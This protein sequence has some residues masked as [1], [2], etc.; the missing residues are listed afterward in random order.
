MSTI[1]N[2]SR[3]IERLESTIR[4]Y[5]HLYYNKDPRITDQEFDALIEALRQVSPESPV[6]SEVGS[7]IDKS[8]GWPEVKHPYR[9]RSLAN[10]MTIDEYKK[11]IVRSRVGPGKEL[12]LE[13]KLDGCAIDLIYENGE[14]VQALTRGDG[15]VGADITP[16]VRKM[17]FFKAKLPESINACIY[18]EVIM[19]KADFEEL[20][21]RL[22]KKKDG[23]NAFAN[24][25]NAATGISH[26][27]DGLYSDSLSLV[28]Y[29]IESTDINFSWETEKMEYLSRNLDMVT[30]MYRLLDRE[31]VIKVRQEY[32]DTER[33]KL[34]VM[35]DG[36]VVKI[37]RIQSVKM[38][39]Y[40]SN[41]DPIGH[42]AFKFEQRGVA[43]MVNE[44]EWR[45]GRTGKVTPLAWF[46]PVSYNGTTVRKATLCNIDEVKRLN[47]KVGDTVLLVKAGE[48]IPKVIS[49]IE[50]SEN[51]VSIPSCCTSCNASLTVI[52]ADLFCTNEEC[53]GRN[54]KKYKHFIDILKKNMGLEDVGE[55][56]IEKLQE[57]G[58]LET[59]ADFFSIE[60][61]DIAGLDRIGEKSARKV[62]EGLQACKNMDAG[63]FLMLLGVKGL[64]ES[65]SK[66]LLSKYNVSSIISG[67][68]GVKEMVILDGIDTLTATYI[69]EGLAAV[70]T[71]IAEMFANGVN[72]IETKEELPQSNILAG[73]SFEISGAFTRTNPS[74][75]DKWD[76][77]EIYKLIEANGGTIKSLGKTSG[78]DY[79]VNMRGFGKKTE[80]ADKLGIKTIGE[81]EFW[82][83][84]ESNESKV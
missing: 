1:V 71:I 25:R 38:L 66:L 79:F 50:S 42:I 24:P 80:A 56:L 75:G 10:A 20:I 14:F 13:E 4:F 40:M 69:T 48:I 30:P 6:L 62:Y 68:I 41:G 49:V 22:P 5:R 8:M 23:S 84:L 76:R 37:N 67:E 77:D 32:M 53:P 82:N 18:G 44:I 9:M 65:T 70:Q 83:L 55:S 43:A 15:V 27:F 81:E 39:G 63:T 58:H 31:E 29:G 57:N 36:L 47:V 52:G 28:V 7:P 33:D 64:G 11:F 59:M 78:P 19:L 74:T 72:I 60:L 34:G 46:D 54:L 51:K 45:T 12:V 35:I 21:Q 2:K 3:T 26:R 61:S 73:K 16:N 17:K